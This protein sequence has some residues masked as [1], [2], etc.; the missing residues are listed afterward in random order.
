MTWEGD[1]ERRAG[2]NTEFRE[3]SW[4]EETTSGVWAGF[5]VGVAPEQE[6]G[7]PEGVTQGIV[8]AYLVLQK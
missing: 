5:L 2:V 4:Q 6:G 3:G 1:S 8:W 7:L